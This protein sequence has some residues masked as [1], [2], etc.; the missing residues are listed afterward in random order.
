MVALSITEFLPH[1]LYEA[2]GRKVWNYVKHFSRN[3]E[4]LEIVYNPY[5]QEIEVYEPLRYILRRGPYI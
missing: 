5:A 3:P 1:G 4:T 2:F